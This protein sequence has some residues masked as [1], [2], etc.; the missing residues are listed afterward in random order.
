MHAKDLP[1]PAPTQVK[2]TARIAPLSAEVKVY[3]NP[4]RNGGKLRIDLPANES[5]GWSFTL[6]NISGQKVAQG[7]LPADAGAHT[8]EISLASGLQ[9]GI[10]YLSLV[11]AGG[12]AAVLP[13]AVE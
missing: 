2:R 8:S 11:H 9:P 3:P 5:G 13:L 1:Q 7:A 4:V 6:L 12:Q 10:Y